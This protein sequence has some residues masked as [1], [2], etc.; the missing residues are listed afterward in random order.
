MATIGAS[1]PY[2]AIYNPNNGAPTYTGGGIMGALVE[3]NF[4]LESTDNNNFYADNKVKESQ[5]RFTNGTVSVTPDD[6]SQ[7]VSA[8][9]LGI[10][11]TPITGIEGITDEDATE[12]IWDDDQDSPYLGVG[13]IQKKQVDSQNRWRAIVLAKVIFDIPGDAAVTEGEEIDWQTTELVGSILRDDSVKHRWKYEATFTT[14]TQA[15]IYLR[16]RLN[17]PDSVP[18]LVDLTGG[19]TATT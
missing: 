5:R 13:L 12:L 18:S 10:A 1:R 8:D 6:L 2:Y 3:F 17:I 4:E 16:A 14:E 7:E 19:A 9:M 11:P 15:D